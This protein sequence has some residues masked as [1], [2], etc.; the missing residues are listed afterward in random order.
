[1]P[2]Q[3]KEDWERTCYICQCHNG[4]EAHLLPFTTI[5]PLDTPHQAFT[6]SGMLCINGDIPWGIHRWH[7]D[8]RYIYNDPGW[9]LILSTMTPRPL[10]PKKTGRVR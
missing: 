7:L 8:G 2:A 3:E 6:Y 5:G 4:Q 9:D 10:G 1:M